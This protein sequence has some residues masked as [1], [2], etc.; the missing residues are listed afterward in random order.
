MDFR[1]LVKLENFRTGSSSSSAGTA[2][3]WNRLPMSIPAERGLTTLRR[4]RRRRVGAELPGIHPLQWVCG[5]KPGRFRAKKV[6]N[7]LIGINT[8]MAPAVLSPGQGA[9]WEPRPRFLSGTSLQRCHRSWPDVP[10]TSLARGL[11]AWPW[12]FRARGRAELYW[13]VSWQRGAWEKSVDQQAN[14]GARSDPGAT[15]DL[16]RLSGSQGDAPS[17][18]GTDQG[19]R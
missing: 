9:L 3:T 14:R 10:M 2:T 7:F 5:G 17:L 18:K 11:W 8:W 6:N 19:C 16:G 15:L 12:V 1:S 4:A 13:F